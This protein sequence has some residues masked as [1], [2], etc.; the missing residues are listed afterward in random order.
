MH[1]ERWGRRERVFRLIIMTM[2]MMMIKIW[3]C[4]KGKCKQMS[5]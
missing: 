2:M 4:L 1:G 3:C 5:I